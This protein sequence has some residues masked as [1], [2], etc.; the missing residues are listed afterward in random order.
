L[1]SEAVQVRL[2]NQSGER[3]TAVPPAPLPALQ[4]PLRGGFGMGPHP[5]SPLR[6]VE[7]AP[8]GLQEGLG[9]GQVAGRGLVPV[10][11]SDGFGSTIGR[12]VSPWDAPR[13]SMPDQS[14]AGTGTGAGTGVPGH[15]AGFFSSLRVVGQVFGGY[16]VCEK[17]DCMVLIDQH[18]AHE[19]VMFERLRSAYRSGSV[20]RQHLLVPAVVEVGARAATL[21]AEQVEDLDGLGFEIEPYG[22]A[23]FAVRAVPALLG[24]ADPG[25]VLRDLAEDLVEVGRSRR[26]AEAAE[27]VLARLACHS[28]VRVGQDLRPEQ[29][30]ALLAAMDCV[31]FSGN[32]PHGRPAYLTFARGEVE[33]W[34]RRT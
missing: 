15:A 16:L 31:D 5:A 22:G 6:L 14:C 24:D 19:R 30:R 33:R 20:Q 1:I 18:A 28:A 4:M 23:S 13:P 10:P 25:G 9:G 29:I 12:P 26:V 8:D 11:E 27:A 7:Q 34:F 21:L 2:R 3:P 32:C 17:A